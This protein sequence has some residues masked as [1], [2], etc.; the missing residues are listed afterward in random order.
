M[1]ISSTT[2]VAGPFTGDG[3]TTT[4]PFTFKAFL[5]TDIL[6]VTLVTATGA[7][8]TLELTTDYTAALNANQDSSAGGSITLTAGG[9]AVGTKLVLTTGIPELQGLD[10]TNGGAFYPDVINAAL[11]LLTILL[12]Q[13]ATQVNLSLQAPIVDNAPAMTLP[14]AAERAGK[15]LMFDSNGNPSLIAL[16]P[17][18]GVPGAQTAGGTLDGANK[19]FTFTAA[20]S[21]VPIPL[22]FAGGVFQTPGTDYGTPA[23]V[24]G[25]TWQI[26]FTTA[27]VAGP[28]TILQFA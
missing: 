27:P 7:I 19:I 15:L 16:A 5:A 22:I 2:R 12:Q 17:G 9:L 3:A 21:A 28:I 13:L 8:A 18:S 23:F 24:S 25:A 1:T 11:D 4:F 10:L 14:A 20:A 6:A 26:T